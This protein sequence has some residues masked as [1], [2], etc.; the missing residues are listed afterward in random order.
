MAQTLTYATLFSDIQ[1]YLERGG[2]LDT[3]V[4]NQIPRF[5]MYAENRLAVELKGLCG[6]RVVTSSFVQGVS[7][8]L[9]PVRWRD[10]VNFSYVNGSGERVLLLP[11]SYEFC[12]E[13]W[14]DATVQDEPRYYADYD[15]NNWLVTPTPNAVRVFELSYYERVQPLDGTN[16][17]NWFTDNAPQILLQACMLEAMLFLKNDDRIAVWKGE[18]DRSLQAIVGENKMRQSDDVQQRGDK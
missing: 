12:R 2:V 4:Y 10:T 9:K 17:T 16:Q 11:R 18:Y 7:T 5:I 8:I 13:F 15:F 1:Q 3:D 14:P 6:L